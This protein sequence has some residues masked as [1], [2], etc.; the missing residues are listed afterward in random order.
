MFWIV[1]DYLFVVAIALHGLRIVENSSATITILAKTI[2]TLLA[3]ISQAQTTR[4]GCHLLAL[5]AVLLGLRTLTVAFGVDLCSERTTWIWSVGMILL[6]LPTMDADRWSGVVAWANLRWCKGTR[7]EEKSME[8][9]LLPLESEP[10]QNEDLGRQKDASHL[11]VV[12]GD[13]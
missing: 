11:T 9:L 2:H 8:H 6:R 1:E 12:K 10:V 5:A 3:W 13:S 4:P 7:K